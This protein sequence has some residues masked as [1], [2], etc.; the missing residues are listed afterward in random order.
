MSWAIDLPGPSNPLARHPT[1]LLHRGQTST[2]IGARGNQAGL[3]GD[4]HRLYPVADTEFHQ[5]V[6]HVCFYGGFAEVQLTRDLAVAKPTGDD[7]QDVEL[8]RG[9]RTESA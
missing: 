4:H 7:L 8:A 1:R 6:A 3:V 5:H 9:Q 2:Q